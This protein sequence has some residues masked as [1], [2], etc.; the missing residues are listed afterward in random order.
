MRP[1]RRGSILMLHWGYFKEV[2]EVAKRGPL[3]DFER[4]VRLLLAVVLFLLARGYG[5]SGVEAIGAIVLGAYVLVTALT[6][7]CPLDAWLARLEGT[8]V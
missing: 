8:G 5:W 3:G 2:C 7:F 6:R 4:G 1:A